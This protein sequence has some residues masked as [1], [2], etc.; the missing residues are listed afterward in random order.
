MRRA[1]TTAAVCVFL[2]SAALADV[3]YVNAGAT[4]AGDG[5]TWADAFPDLQAAI[6]AST[7]GDEIWVAAG[8][9]LPTDTADRTISFAL[10]DGVGIYGGFDG[11]EAM[12]TER[13]P[14]A[15]VTILSGDIGVPA[16]TADNSYHVVTTDGTV[17][18]SA[19]LDGFT[20]TAGQANGVDPHVRGGG[21]WMNG[22][23]PTLANLRFVSNF[24]STAGGGLRVSSGS[25][26]M[27]RC[28]FQ[29]NSVA[30][31]GV[32]GGLSLEV[33]ATASCRNCVFRS[34]SVS[35]A[36]V[37]SGGISSGGGLTLV[38]TIVAQNSPNG[39]HLS[40]DNH[41]L[42][43]CTVAYNSA[44]GIGLFGSNANALTNTVIWG[45]GTDGIFND[46]S[47]SVSASYCDT[48]GGVLSGTG[49]ISAN[50]LFLA[51]PGD[52]RPG[53]G[54]PV[55]DAGNNAAVPVGVTTDVA[56]L[57]RFFDDPA[58]PD[59]GAGTPPIVDLGAHE[60][61]PLA[62]S[63]PSGLELCAGAEAEFSVVA[64][65]Q[66]P[67]SYQWRLGGTPLSD[68]GRI[69]GSHTD[70][71]TIAQTIPGDA[72]SYDVVV[73]DGVGQ[74]LTSTAA[75]LAVNATP[76]APTITAP[77]SVPVAST[78]NGASVVSNAGSAW[79]WTLTGGTITGGQGTSQVTFDAGGAGTTM[80][81]SVT[82]TNAGCTSPVAAF[83]IQVDF[84]DVPPEDPFHD[85]VIS[86]A[87]AGI[88]AGCGGGNYCR[89]DPVTRAQMAVFLLKSKYGSSFAPPPCTGIFTDVAC[90]STFA[91]WIEELSV[92]GITAGCG[93]GLYC[94]NAAVTR[95]QMAVFLL[96]TENGSAYVPPVCAGIFDDVA[97][98]SLYADWIEKIYA[99]AVTGGCSASPLLYCPTDPNT[100]GQMAVFLVKAFDLP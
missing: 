21:M 98:P 65:G 18:L 60:R 3:I 70:T 13:D 51:P 7:S 67:L 32:G 42:E 66:A 86:V 27:T 72:G 50:P 23:S 96:R 89:N 20:V 30:F 78:A 91:N 49:N 5:T 37:G 29:S 41:T 40:N 15:N 75:T 14:A 45:N 19:V 77:A 38:N 34:N 58:A 2:S 17:T 69:G 48:Q 63:A 12:R 4:G 79:N 100:R 59:T 82:E 92:E 94:P 64:T 87:R 62:V 1:L 73:T 47:S 43:N 44:Y 55:V 39:M 24:A 83:A 57:P 61:V 6:A 26:A 28:V 31:G 52:L 10:R 16:S 11:T 95:Q 22:G 56:G 46:G 33:G 35:G 85:F 76:V 97:C 90:P 53:P 84:L 81:L 68:G 93:P 9:Y 74:S 88:T 99:D 25:A 36:V 54:S 80:L 8:T 71:L